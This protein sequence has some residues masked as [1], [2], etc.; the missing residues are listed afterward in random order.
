MPSRLRRALAATARAA[1]LAAS[2]LLVGACG[3]APTPTGSGLGSSAPSTPLAVDPAE[4]NGEPVVLDGRDAGFAL[5][6]RIRS[7]AVDAGA[8]IDVAAVL[9]WEGA[10]QRATIWGSG[11][12]PVT[13]G[14]AQVDGDIRM[15]AVQTADCAKHEYARGAPVLTPFRK[16]GG[17]PD[18]DPNAA[19]YRAFFAD[20][21]LRLPAGRWLVTATANGYL[22]PCE[23]DAPM[24]NIRLEA[25]ILV[26]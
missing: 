21:V 11:G 7:D 5:S 4:P 18:D 2:V 16:S 15:D 12:G 14:I 10:D 9:A 3:Q 24:V 1:T 20:P 6:L 22:V 8:P 25:E 26:R 17:F 19:F 23:M 13:F